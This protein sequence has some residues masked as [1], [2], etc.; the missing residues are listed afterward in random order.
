[1]WRQQERKS[2]RRLSLLMWR[3]AARR[4]D[5]DRR[6]ESGAARAGG[7]CW[8]EG[9]PGGLSV[10]TMTLPGRNQLNINGLG[11]RYFPAMTGLM[12]GQL[13]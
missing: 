10:G 3:L 8:I 2:L 13:S 1:M 9:R 12:E 6:R 4:D 11:S 5:S 7:H